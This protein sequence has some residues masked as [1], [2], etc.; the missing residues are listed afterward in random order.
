MY[1]I[2]KKEISVQFSLS[3]LNLSNWNLYLGRHNFCSWARTEIKS[4]YQ[5]I[6]YSYMLMLFLSLFFHTIKNTN[7]GHKI[8]KIHQY[9]IKLT[10]NKKK[11]LQRTKNTPFLQDKLIW[12]LP[13]VKKLQWPNLYLSLFL[14]R[15]LFWLSSIFWNI[16]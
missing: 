15:S 5:K 11:S 3:F 14:L 16:S 6:M 8:W 2:K 12:E 4:Y 10:K 13:I 1:S 9:A 7:I